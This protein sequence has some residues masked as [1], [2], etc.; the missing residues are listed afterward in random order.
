MMGENKWCLM[1]FLNQRIEYYQ[2]FPIAI[3]RFTIIM[4][5][6]V[7]LVAGCYW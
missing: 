1:H 4:P 3:D 7:F 2:A 6:E 5:F